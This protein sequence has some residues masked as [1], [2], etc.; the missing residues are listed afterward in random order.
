M[1][2]RGLLTVAG[3]M[4]LLAWPLVAA[5][6]S[7]ALEQGSVGMA[8]PDIRSGG[9][10]I[11][12]SQADIRPS[13]TAN[14][15]FATVEFAPSSLVLTDHLV[16]TGADQPVRLNNLRT[17]LS[18]T[19]VTLDYGA[20]G[21]WA[22][23]IAI[24]GDIRIDVTRVEH[25][26]LLP[27]AWNF[28][29]RAEGHLADLRVQ[30]TLVSASGLKADL[31]IQLRPDEGV[32]VAIDSVIEG[33]EGVRTLA[34]TLSRWPELLTVDSGN[35]RLSME[36]STGQGGEVAA[37]GRVD[38]QDVGGVFNRTAVSGLTGE[39]RGSLEGSRMAARFRDIT[40]KEIN[41]G[42]P[43]SS[44][45]FSGDYNA[46]LADLL[47]GTLD[48]QQASAGFL[49]GTLRVPP[50]EYDL[51][52]GSGRVPLEVEDISLSRLMEVYP[53]EGLSG[54]GRLHGRIPLGI[55]GDGVQVSAGSLSAIAP[56]GRL[57]L[58]A[59]RLQAMLGGNQAMDIV[60]QALQNFHYSVLNSTIDYDEKGKLSLGLR[61]EG[62]NPDLRDGQP[63][64]LN[65]NLE[66]NIPA[67]LT[68]LQ[69][70][71]R[72]NEAVTRRVR[73]LLQ[74][75]GEEKAP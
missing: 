57:Q 3:A 13:V 4:A 43:V 70:S 32:S 18:N 28:Q 25:P 48:V 61:L 35:A 54:S 15:D 47:A 29:G 49:E 24:E 2:H 55:S 6:W 58:P 7:F 10:E 19:T 34:E 23:R 74:E 53:A 69:L 68:S 14:G 8:L 66:E 45:R 5:G 9:W 50:A 64:V 72:V 37:S 42:I 30:G 41:A 52:G 56:G 46:P 16:F 65:V 75:S 17:D 38:L 40:V 51:A 21:S 1:I 36:V 44:V 60:V 67:L 31:D 26:Q 33:Q 71:G 39:V 22:K 63:V 73:K 59:D 20:T 27:Q 62:K 11:T 12:G